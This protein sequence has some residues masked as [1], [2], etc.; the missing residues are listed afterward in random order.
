ASGAAVQVM[1]EIR[2][3]EKTQ[4]HEEYSCVVVCPEV[5]G[6]EKR[7]FGADAAQAA[8][9]AEAFILTLWEH[10]GIKTDEAKR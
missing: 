2:V 6:D 7:I 1:A 10:H 9:L 8:E 5:L 3:P 4:A